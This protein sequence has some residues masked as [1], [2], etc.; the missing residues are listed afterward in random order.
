[1]RQPSSSTTGNTG[2]GDRSTTALASTMLAFPDTVTKS[3]STTGSMKF[4][5]LIRRVVLT[6]S[7]GLMITDTRRSL[8]SSTSPDESLKP[9]VSTSALTP[10]SIAGS[11]IVGRSP[12]TTISRSAGYCCIRSVNP[13]ALIAP[14]IT[15]SS[16]RCCGSRT[17]WKLPPSTSWIFWRQ[18]VTVRDLIES[19]SSWKNR[20]MRFKTERTPTTFRSLPTT[21]IARRSARCIRW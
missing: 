10:C 13:S 9:P 3:V 18:V 1:M 12:Q 16:S 21:G 15:R 11:W 6:V 8:A 2:C 7:N 20:S 14:T 17:C 19:P 5:D 4:D